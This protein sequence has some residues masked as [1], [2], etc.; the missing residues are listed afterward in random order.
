MRRGELVNLKWNHI[1]RENNFI[2]LPA[3]LT[4]ENK[5]KSIP[6][7]HHVKTTLEAL[8]R[9]LHHEYVSTYG[10]KPISIRFRTGFMNACESAGI[11]Y[12]QNVEG[13]LRFHDLRATFDTNMDR[14]GVS[15][16]CRKA[17]LGHSFRGMDRHYLRLSDEDLK[18][19]VDKYTTWIDTQFANVTQSVTQEEKN[20]SY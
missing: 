11:L 6:M 12:G 8:P 4:K 14:A 20:V 19:A 7:N 17:I 13:G 10:G 16:S 1:D 5:T 18:E 15:E 3:E 9:A 2:H